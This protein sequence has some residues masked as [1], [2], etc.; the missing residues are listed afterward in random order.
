MTVE[1]TLPDDLSAARVARGHV[2]DELALRGVADDIADDIL[3][4][5][6]ELAANAVRYGHPPFVL[7]VDYVDDRVRVT[8]TN[9]GSETDPVVT[10]AST[11]DGSGRG[12][13]IIRSLAS[14]LGWTREA[15]RLDVWAEMRLTPGS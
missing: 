6:S 5:T 8:T 7:R 12:L 15:D 4:I 11:H 9:H 14:D 13:A 1:W 3:L 2:A 10:Q